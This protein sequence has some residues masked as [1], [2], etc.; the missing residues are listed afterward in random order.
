[1]KALDLSITLPEEAFSARGL[2]SST[3]GFEFR[4]SQAK[5]ASLVWE[6]FKKG[7]FALIEAGTGTGKSLA[8][9]YPG[10]F[11]TAGK[12]SIGDPV[13]T[14]D[15][16]REESVS[17]T[18]IATHTINLQQQLIEKD[19][20]FLAKATNQSLRAALLM[21]RSN[22]LCRR[23]LSF[24]QVNK[25]K[26]T[27]EERRSVTK[28]ISCGEEAEG[29]L[30][31]IGVTLSREFRLMLVSESE[32]CLRGHCP[33]LQ[34]CY[35]YTAK[36]KAFAAQVVVVNHHL[37][38]ADLALRTGRGRGGGSSEKDFSQEKL[39]LPPYEHVVFDEAH[40]LEEVATTYLGI[41]LD[42]IEVERFFHRLLRKDGRFSGGR[43]ITLRH[44]LLNKGADLA[45][46]QRQIGL[47]ETELI[48]ELSELEG[49]Y[50]R[51]FALLQ[52]DFSSGAEGEEVNYRFTADL[53]IE[54]DLLKETVARIKESS[55]AW[56]KKVSLFLDEL[57]EAQ[58]DEEFREDSI[59]LA[60][61]GRY[62]SRMRMDLPVLLN[63]DEDA[64]VHW[65]ETKKRTEAGKTILHR[66]P[67]SIGN[68]LYNNLFTQVKSAVCTSATLAVG[69]QFGYIKE[70][71]GLDLLHPSERRE[72]ILDSP[73]DYNRQVLVMVSK[74]LPF[75]DSPLFV[76]AVLKLLPRIIE[77]TRGRT[78]LLFTN[79]RQ[80]QEVYQ[81]VAPILKKKGYNLF[82][83]GET[84]R[85]R[86]LKKYKTASS[87]VLFG[88]DSFWE[89]VD[90]PGPQLSTVVIMRLPFRV[91][92]E[93]LFQT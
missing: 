51:L 66:L 23:K 65:L 29:C 32:T 34:S 5:M 58:V 85:H 7:G 68:L 44:S 35:W 31:Q 62:L 33:F 60:E 11:S 9:L 67:L 90:I 45:F 10:F 54:D 84:S 59:F 64:F 86:L 16:S 81:Q 4:S 48:P 12:K 1:M 24:I 47:L 55:E 3:T 77:A 6:V 41:R 8:Y 39:V 88:T 69:K 63:G 21:G 14:A 37:F 38:F 43:L 18:I 46:L 17:R 50:Q 89:G 61:T 36:K 53:Q 2:F 30:E 49:C 87:P 80:M 70:R 73:F 56:E 93:P 52:N 15:Y 20:P 27:P 91:P 28:L 83:Q 13:Q 82:L 40:H 74:D 76:Q 57:Q 26:L 72:C 92:T 79:H 71:L 22:Y 75:P 25:D 19:I 78:L 42:Q